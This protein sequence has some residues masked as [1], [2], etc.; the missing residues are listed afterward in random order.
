MVHI[1]ERVLRASQCAAES[2]LEACIWAPCPQL[3][4]CSCFSV[5]GEGF[6]EM[7]CF[8]L[9]P[10]K[11]G[12]SAGGVRKLVNSHSLWEVS[13]DFPQCRKCGAL[14]SGQFSS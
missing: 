4:P 14:G 7:C 2:G 9:K 5:S 13:K 3:H 12:V 6:C 10:D 1:W 8:I 11:V